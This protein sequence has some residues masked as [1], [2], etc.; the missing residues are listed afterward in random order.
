MPSPAIS[1][2]V[3]HAKQP[4]GADLLAAFP[5]E[6]FD[7]H[8]LTSGDGGPPFRPGTPNVAPV[9]TV[10][11]VDWEAWAQRLARTLDRPPEIVANDEY[12]LEACAALRAATGAAPRHP[13]G[14]ARYR[15]KVAMKEALAAAGVDVPPHVKL[16]P[17][18]AAA[19]VAA[20]R[21]AA[22]LGL[23]LVVKPRREANNR[24]VEVIAH[25]DA[26]CAWLTAHAG[27]SGWQ[28]EAFVAGRQCHANALV[29]DGRIAPLLVGEYTDS[30]LALGE[31]QPVGSVTLA[32]DDP[33]VAA[34]ERLNERALA[35]L[36]TD[37][38]FVVHTEFV[39]TAD[40]RTVFLEAAARAP[41]A[42][43]SEVAALHTGVHLEQANLRMQAG[44]PPPR[45]RSTGLHAA[46]MW[47][48]TPAG[49]GTPS[50][51]QLRLRSDFRLQM[52]PAGTPLAAGLVAWNRDL[53]TLRA[54]LAELRA[55]PPLA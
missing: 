53:T 52:L 39:L 43:V 54:D 21:L 7:V 47:F 22:T 15:D 23:P 8:V 34:G 12:C 44:E 32:P 37:G 4:L 17:V 45:S 38:R 13:A 18:P 51:R 24:G 10:A 5:P 42:L 19:G 41:G 49:G 31:C 25:A 14:L 28:A 11:L 36:G 48:P 35:A 3:L 50:V 16:D 2:V 6:R 1:V 55:D 30:L 40:G 46:W 9:E 20:D 26:L 27:R 33:A 29:V